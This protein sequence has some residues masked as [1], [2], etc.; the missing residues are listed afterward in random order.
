MPQITLYEYA[1][2]R[3]QKCRWAI[4]EA[5]LDYESV[6]NSI[7]VLTSDDLKAIQPLGKLP[8]AIIDGKPLFESN[9]IVAAIADLAPHRKLIPEPGSWERSLYDQW[10]FFATTELEMWAWSTMLNTWT[11]F[12]DESD[13]IPAIA[14]QNAEMFKR[15]AGAIEQRLAANAHILGEDFSVA[16][17]VVGY[18]LNLGRGVGFLADGFPHANAYLDRLYAREHCTLTKPKN[19]D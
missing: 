14:D 4:A 2:T 8:A 5:G 1:P 3:S 17:I 11:F 18:A 10:T 6:G 7:E 13:R 15:G 19:S 9:A 12:L 16:D